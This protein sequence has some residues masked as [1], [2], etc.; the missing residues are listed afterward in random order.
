MVVLNEAAL[1]AVVVLE[2]EQ[3]VLAIVKLI[4]QSH[5]VQLQVFDHLAA[6]HQLHLQLGPFRSL[7]LQ[8]L[9]T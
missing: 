4:A 5:V 3:F 1:V 8:N 7:A 6:S 2:G 9:H